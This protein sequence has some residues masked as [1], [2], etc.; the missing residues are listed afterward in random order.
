MTALLWGKQSQGAMESFTYWPPVPPGRPAIFV[1]NG[2][3]G[4]GLFRAQRTPRIFMRG[5]ISRDGKD[6]YSWKLKALVKIAGGI[7]RFFA[8]WN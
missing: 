4:N 3:S 5:H 1:G 7:A 2:V 8:W 6:V